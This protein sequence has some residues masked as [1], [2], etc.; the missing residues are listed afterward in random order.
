[1]RLLYDLS[2][3]RRSIRTSFRITAGCDGVYQ[4]G[5]EKYRKEQYKIEL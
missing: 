1:M 3:N 5:K 2:A 4:K